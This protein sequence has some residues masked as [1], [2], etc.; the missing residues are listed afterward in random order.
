VFISHSSK[1]KVFA[2]QLA[3][4]LDVASVDFFLDERDIAG[5]DS[6]PERVF[7]AISEASHAIYV[8]SKHSVASRWVQDEIGAAKMR[9]LGGD[10][11]VV[12]PVLLD[13]S[14]LPTQVAHI[15]YADFRDWHLIENY[16]VAVRALLA[17]IGVAVPAVS[18]GRTVEWYRANF[19]EFHLIEHRVIGTASTLSMALFAG[20]M[21][22]QHRAEEGRMAF[23]TQ[24]WDEFLF[25]LLPDFIDVLNGED[26]E[27]L[28]SLRLQLE[29][30]IESC[31]QCLG[32][33]GRGPSEQ[34]SL[35]VDCQR[36]FEA[37]SSAVRDVR[38]AVESV[39]LATL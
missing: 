23:K 4:S 36:R 16:R 38:L 3:A 34:I 31:N 17:A 6:I 33:R 20:V 37:L 25:R 26:Q 2:R 18:P 10:S 35:F 9:Q 24:W 32:S 39:L 19:S 21:T 7:A 30:T 22:P 27:L 15:R 14:E 1:D 8:I 29:L 13:E 12:L 28:V 5:G 11:I